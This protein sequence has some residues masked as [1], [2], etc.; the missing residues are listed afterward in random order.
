MIGFTSYKRGGGRVEFLGREGLVGKANE[1]L[2][3]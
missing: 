1:V 2:P 3:F